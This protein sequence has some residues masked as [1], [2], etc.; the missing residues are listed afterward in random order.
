M[1]LLSPRSLEAR[2]GQM[3]FVGFEGLTA[4]TYILDWLREGRIG[5]IILFA[6][7]VESPA[8]V[9]ALTDSLQAAATYGVIISIDQEGGMVA[10]LRE[11]FT[12]SPGAMALASAAHSEAL[13]QEAAH[14]LAQEL[15]ALGIHWN[16]APV[17]DIAYNAKNPS[18]GTRTFGSDPELVSELGAATVRGLQ[19]AGIAASPKHF[20]S[21]SHTEIDTHIALPALDTSL[22]E[23]RNIDLMPY[24]AAI[25]A[26]T[27][28]IMVTH[29]LYRALDAQF[30][31]TMSPIVVNRLLRDE[32]KYDGVVTTDCM[33]MQAITNHYGSA[34]SAVLAALAGMDS[35]LFSHT[36]EKQESA[37]AA[38]LDAA[39]SGRLPEARIDEANRRLA[40]FKTLYLK[41]RADLSLVAASEHVAFMEEAARASITLLKRG[42][43][44]PLHGRI[45]IVEFP[46][47]LES[48]IN[49]SG[50]LTGF[51]K[52]L[53]ARLP[54]CEVVTLLSDEARPA[55]EVLAERVE[56]LVLAVRNVHMNAEKHA[57]AEHLVEKA[58]STVL[59]CLR[60]PHDARALPNVDSTLCTCGDSVPSLVAV[61]AALLGDFVPSGVLPVELT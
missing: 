41:P 57:F 14:I 26:G 46:S 60:N 50:G 12:E 1:T 17:L 51:S 48:G 53:R 54:E 34:E 47:A 45:G 7:N 33:E 59:V 9:A 22:D 61:V 2:V 20:P 4:P 11:G 21:A 38:L 43:A 36:R 25:A 32:L 42:N 8:Q 35:I 31:S 49:E 18:M 56:T 27:A 44:L 15:R 10:R 55:A 37:Y 39:H 3:L 58:N 13:T 5:G 23:L 6:R 24:R 29:V 40:T 28:S 19:S 30:P 52:L 16:Y